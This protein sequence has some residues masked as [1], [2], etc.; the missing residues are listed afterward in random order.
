MI[1]D[2]LS[3]M[4]EWNKVQS[5]KNKNKNKLLRAKPN[6]K[7][8]PAVPQKSAPAKGITKG[9]NKI[10]ASPEKKDPPKV[11]EIDY[12][13]L[14]TQYNSDV[15]IESS[16]DFGDESFT[17]FKGFLCGLYMRKKI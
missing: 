1:T 2:A 14:F 17:A 15:S 10:F 8:I 4:A 16:P 5:N 9:A 7:V 13:K 12:G 11:D 6:N 3:E